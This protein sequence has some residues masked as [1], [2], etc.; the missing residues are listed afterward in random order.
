MFPDGAWQLL[1]RISACV[2]VSSNLS[3]FK[4]EDVQP[5]IRKF[6]LRARG[7]PYAEDVN[8]TGSDFYSIVPQPEMEAYYYITV[9][10]DMHVGYSIVAD[11]K[12]CP[13]P[14]HFSNRKSSRQPR[15]L[16]TGFNES[17]ASNE[18]A[19]NQTASTLSAVSQL[20]EDH[21]KVASGPSSATVTATPTEF[22]S[23]HRPLCEGDL[24]RAGHT[25]CHARMPSHDTPNEDQ[26]RARLLGLFPSTGT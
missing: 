22:P 13:T 25:G 21:Q 16:T 3:A 6:G 18:T 10:A 12:D 19:S 9:A 11:I 4:S 15:H 23:T 20:H 1:V 2:N 17:D 7:L 5:C 24:G 8:V 26:A 14:W